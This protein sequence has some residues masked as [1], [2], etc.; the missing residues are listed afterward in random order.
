[1]STKP[2]YIALRTSEKRVDRHLNDRKKTGQAPLFSR[3]KRNGSQKLLSYRA[4]A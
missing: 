2:A 3:G 1:M 4:Q